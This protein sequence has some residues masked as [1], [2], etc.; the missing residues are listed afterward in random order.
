M[1]NETE[2]SHSHSAGC[3][4]INELLSGYV[5]NELTQQQ[6]QRVA[7]HLENCEACRANLAQMEQ[8]K[9]AIQGSAVPE[10]EADRID[11]ILN[12]PKAKLAENLGWMAVIIGV[13][14]AL[15]YAIVGFFGAT[16]I[17]VA[18]KI[19]TSLIWGGLSGVFIAV[20]RQQLLARKTDKY[21]GVK[22]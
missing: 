20:V 3:E 19:V 4:D 10:L 18:E 17:S 16:D 1:K 2:H 8:L 6:S 21:K 5:D 11:A 7:L 9:T 15:A 13:S 14:I 22:L 12:D